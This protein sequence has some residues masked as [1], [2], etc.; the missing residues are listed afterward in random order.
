M[1]IGKRSSALPVNGLR[2][3]YGK[4]SIMHIGLLGG[5]FNPPHIGHLMMARQVLD[6]AGFDEVWFL[7]SYGQHP[8]K[9]HVAPVEDRLAMANMLVFPKTRVCTLEIDNTLDGNTIKLLPFLPKEHDYT[10]VMG[11]DWLP[12]FPL[13]GSWEEL[14][15]KLPFLVFPRSGFANEPLY[16][17][18]KVLDHPSLMTSNISSTKI[19]ERITKG[20][21]ID[22]FVPPNVAKYIKEHGLYK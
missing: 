14:L 5:V 17:N 11:A 1:I 10:F 15:T 16:P 9:P 4:F 8:P 6:Y 2:D 13:W 18:M 12:T 19:R 22:E 7:V 20:L 3:R 21:S